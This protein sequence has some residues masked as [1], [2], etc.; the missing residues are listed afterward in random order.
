[1]AL[2]SAPPRFAGSCAPTRGGKSARNVAISR[3]DAI[4][5]AVRNSRRRPIRPSISHRP[6]ASGG[7]ATPQAARPTLCQIASATFAP[8]RPSAFCTS[9]PDAL[10]QLGSV[11]A[12]VA[13][14][15]NV[16]MAAV[17]NTTP[18][19]RAIRRRSVMATAAR[20]PVH[21]CGNRGT[22]S[23]EPKTPKAECIWLIVRIPVR[24]RGAR[25]CTGEG[26]PTITKCE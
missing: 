11:G 1:M 6:H 5:V 9:A 17:M 25:H 23:A 3:S 13:T 2:P 24:S 12:Y 26:D 15:A 18:R 10:F 14:A 22:R 21:S 7:M 16:P 8:H 20:Q 19:P 4:Q